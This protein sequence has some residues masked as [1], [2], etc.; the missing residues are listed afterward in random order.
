VLR[1]G[2]GREL[3]V[4][5][6]LGDSLSVADITGDGQPDLVAGSPGHP[7]EGVIRGA[8]FQYLSRP[9]PQTAGG[10]PLLQG[11]VGLLGAGTLDPTE[12]KSALGTAMAAGDFD[13]DGRPDL[14]VIAPTFS[15]ESGERS[16]GLLE[17]GR[18][19]DGFRLVALR[20]HTGFDLAS[21]DDRRGH[22]VAAADFNR[23]GFDDVAIGVQTFGAGSE[24]IDPPGALFLMAG[25]P[26]GLSALSQVA[27][28]G[29]PGR[30]AADAF[31]V[32]LAAGDFDGDGHA[33]LAVGAIRSTSP[34]FGVSDAEIADS[35]RGVPDLEPTLRLQVV[36]GRVY[37]FRNTPEG[38]R[39][40][41]T[42]GGG[43]ERE[44]GQRYGAA[45]HASD[46]NGDGVDD[47]VVGAPERRVPGVGPERSGAAFVYAGGAGG[48]TLVQTLTQAGLDIDEEGDRFGLRLSN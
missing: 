9:P 45:L 21:G 26:G 46:L 33:D 3:G 40:W 8:V 38:L 25:G 43:G 37:V 19:D 1:K 44:A 29:L 22:A 32:S 2:F 16:G 24:G 39:P 35:V 5:G 42:L 47:L 7:A 17:F 41:R 11:V 14:A 15:G 31:G 36:T 13:G 28:D 10:G 34:L 48:F 20:M 6:Y 23:D 30:G 18:L 27:A 12:S 4:P